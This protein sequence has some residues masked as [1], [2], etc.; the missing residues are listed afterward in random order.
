[1]GH[2]REVEEFRR[3]ACCGQLFEIGALTADA[4]GRDTP[5]TNPGGVRPLCGIGPADGSGQ[6]RHRGTGQERAEDRGDQLGGRFAHQT[7]AR[8]IRIEQVLGDIL[9][10]RVDLRPRMAGPL[11]IGE[12]H[13]I[14]GTGGQ[15]LSQRARQR[16]HHGW[17][18]YDVCSKWFPTLT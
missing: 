4:H 9:S 8:D 12:Q 3:F 14:V 7:E 16:I 13:Q 5:E 10:A 18:L 1:M 11:A 17:K 6:D 2:R 15:R